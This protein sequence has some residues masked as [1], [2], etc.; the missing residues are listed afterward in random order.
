MGSQG[1]RHDKR[2]SVSLGIVH[3]LGLIKSIITCNH[4]YSIR[5]NIF[6]ALKKPSVNT[7]I[8][9][10]F[11]SK[12]SCFI[13]LA[14][15]YNMV[16][17]PGGTSGKGSTCQ[18]RRLKKLGFNPWVGKIP[19]R[20]ARQLTPVCLFKCFILLSNLILML[21]LWCMHLVLPLC[22][23]LG[24][25]LQKGKEW[26]LKTSWTEMAVLLGASIIEM[27]THS[28]VL[29]WRIPGTGEPGGLSSLGS[30]RVGH[31]WS[32]LA[33]AALLQAT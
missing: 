13:M 26:L 24:N 1:V 4:P 15:V 11:C 5:Q 7:I 2:L 16:G 8:L 33:A 3:S 29:A 19:L 31:D 27:A 20:R 10:C 18:C 14:L 21:T 9:V 30:H 22:M 12:H 6:P 17:F 25:V 28:S 23:G 32:D